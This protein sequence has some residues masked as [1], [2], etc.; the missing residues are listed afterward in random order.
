MYLQK[1]SL[2]WGCLLTLG[3]LVASCEGRP[4]KKEVLRTGNL[5]DLIAVFED[6]ER[7]EQK[8]EY[9][10][11]AK[12]LIDANEDLRSS[13]LYV[14][15]AS[16][17]QQAGYSDSAVAILHQAIDCGMANPTLL[18]KFPGLEAY[19]SDSFKKLKQRLD[20][21]GNILGGVSNFSLE[22]RAM[23][24]FWP[25]L[26]LALATPDSAKQHLKAYVLNGPPEIRDYYAV[27]YY[28]T[29]QMYGQMIN[30]APKYYSYLKSQFDADSLV[31][32]KEHIT[33]A[34][35]RFK[36][37]YPDAVFPK[38]YIVPGLLNSAGTATEMGMFVGG[39]MFG[40]SKDIPVQELSD[41]QRDAI[42]EFNSLPQ[43]ILHELMHFQQNYSDPENGDLVLNKII[44]EGV[45]DF[46]SELASGIPHSSE[47]LDY[48]RSPENF[49][50]ITWQLKLDLFSDDL[51]AWM[52]NGG[53]IEDR[54]ADLGYALGYLITKS[55][56]EKAAD[57][58]RALRELLNAN[59]MRNILAGSDYNYL[60]ADDPS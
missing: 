50:Q 13:Q 26:D 57:K 22:T 43:L 30:G 19:E 4:E 46:L 28:S 10:R 53:S 56:Y 15:A 32:L 3:F 24:Q 49:K 20:S 18:K 31:G 47:Q 41:W 54:P 14:E 59:D 35:L 60:L 6:Y 36:T 7:L 44:E 58:Q 27:R 5:P 1:R 11:M 45:C 29:E 21:L 12:K 39:D 37:L 55:Y 23:Q 25:Y 40:K 42:S 52:Y 2:L 16:L 38:V 34:L 33:S 48:L 51:S 17:Y 9:A 8:G